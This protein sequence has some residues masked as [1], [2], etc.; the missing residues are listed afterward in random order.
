MQ[1]RDFR[2]EIVSES[3][4]EA[5]CHVTWGIEPVNGVEGWVWTNVYGWRDGGEVGED[6]LEGAFV[7]VVSDEETEELFKRVPGFV[8]IEV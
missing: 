1:L 4:A 8:E 2:I 6:G 7:S 5:K 3:P